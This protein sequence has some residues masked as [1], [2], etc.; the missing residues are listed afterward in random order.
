MLLGYKSFPNA[1]LIILV[2]KEEKV[3]FFKLLLDLKLK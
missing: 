3:D 2:S 1:V